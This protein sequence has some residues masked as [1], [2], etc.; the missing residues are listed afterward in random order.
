M[1]G[2]L[3]LQWNFTATL[4]A[5]LCDARTNLTV[6]HAVAEDRT[7]GL[8]ATDIRPEASLPRQSEDQ[9]QSE[10]GIASCQ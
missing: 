6:Q 2:C 7:S 9:I 10:F 4:V 5:A 3:V 1:A 8:P